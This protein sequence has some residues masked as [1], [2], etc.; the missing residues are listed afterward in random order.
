MT[1]PLVP[2]HFLTTAF[3]HC[4]RFQGLLWQLIICT[5][6]LPLHLPTI[7]LLW[8]NFKQGSSFL[9]CMGR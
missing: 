1:W 9:R 7:F 6:W 2:R 5:D 3:F 8:T 4:A